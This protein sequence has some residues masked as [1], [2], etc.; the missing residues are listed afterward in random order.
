[1]SGL[2]L[3]P[4]SV[5]E[6]LD[7]TFTLYRRHFLLFA[8]LAAIPQVPVLAVNLWAATTNLAAD[9]PLGTTMLVSGVVVVMVL[10]AYLFSQGSATWA[11]SQLYLGHTTTIADS[12]R[13]ASRRLGTLFGV[14][15]LNFLA[16]IPA[17]MLLV[18]PGL[19]LTCRL[20]VGVPA[21]VIE[22]H[23]AGNS[24]AR[25][26]LLT[27]GFAGPAFLILLLYFVLYWGAT[28][29]ITV[30]LLFPM[31]TEG[32][33][34]QPSQWVLAATQVISFVVSALL[35][36]VL[37]IATA[38]FY[39]DLRVRKEAFDLQVMLGVEAAPRLD[40]AVPPAL[41]Q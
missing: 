10:I 3:R 1:M 20:L 6:I 11:V 38:V 36:P 7:R 12:L 30:P 5:G 22:G 25:S 9:S 28:S 32:P 40:P 19:Y 2:D 37:L 16:L 31:I 34:A 33:N 15:L 13:H 8:G 35:T 41:P 39:Y 17:F 24:L 29:L 23:S 14:L 27:K 18:I 26:F 4:L 21:A